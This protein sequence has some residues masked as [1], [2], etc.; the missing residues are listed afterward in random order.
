MS[1]KFPNSEHLKS[2]KT[3]GE[4]FQSGMS[5]KVF[6][7]RFQFSIRKMEI[8]EEYMNIGFVVAKK[9]HK[10]AVNRNRIKRQI[11]ES[12]RLNRKILHKKLIEKNL[13]LDMMIIFINPNI[14]SYQHIDKTMIKGIQKL[15]EKL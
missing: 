9:H 10:L 6:P 8:D 5:I 13:H 1:L 3:I 11:R 2:R 7:L 4:L 15:C 14:S 12:F